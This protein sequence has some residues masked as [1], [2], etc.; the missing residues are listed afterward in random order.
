MKI[1]NIDSFEGKRVLVTGASGFIGGRLCI[2]LKELGAEIHAVSRKKRKESEIID[3]WLK[4]DLVD[5][6][7]TRSAI[8]S[9]K[10]DK[11][12]HL[13]GY[14][15]GKRE[16]GA[17]QP[18]Y[19]N[20]LTTTINVLKVSAELGI[21]RLTLAGSMEEPEGEGEES[22]PVSPY[23]ASKGAC[24][25][26][27]RMFYRL[28]GTPV[29]IPR[30]YMV[31]GPG[32]QNLQR[33]IPYVI[34]CL[35]H[36]KKPKLSSGTRLIDWIYIDDVVDGLIRMA[37]AEG[38]EGKIIDLGSGKQYSIQEVCEKIAAIMNSNISLGFGEKKDRRFDRN[39]V[40]D[41]GM[42]KKY[43]G[44]Q[45]KTEID[46]GLTNTVEWFKNQRN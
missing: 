4:G 9:V 13:A 31:Y 17:V 36:Q 22:I 11:I 42:A 34:Q 7:F 15:S 12:F 20:N 33:L 16:L 30:I 14:V 3:R 40:A 19:D 46:E 18:N 24:T 27:A 43:L 2:K 10:P 45:P 25:E 28:Y 38:I 37:N 1:N 41:L 44:W 35:I 26:Y 39:W 8:K 6:D 5:F 32:K 21:Q 23:A 29:T